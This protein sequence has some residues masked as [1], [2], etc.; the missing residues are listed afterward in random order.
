[1]TKPWRAF[2]VVGTAIF[3]TILDLFIVNTALPAVAAEFPQT[4]VAHLSWVLTIYAIVF[5][6]VLVPAGKFG[7]LYGRRRFFIGGM[8]VFVLGSVIASLAPN[9]ALLLAGR[10]V[11]AVGAASITPNSLAALLP[12][13]PPQRRPAVIAAWGALAGLGGLT[14]PALGGIL[15]Q[16]DWR[17]IFLIN[18]PVGLAALA[19]TPRFIPEVR[20][21]AASARPDLI[22]AALLAVALAALTL[23]LSQGPQWDW[24][25]RGLASL[26]LAAV[27]VVVVG[28]RSRRHPAPIIEPSLLSGPVRRLTMAA[29][30]VFWAAFAILLVA[31]A[32][33]MTHVWGFS[34]L[35]T[36]L[37]LTPGPAIAVVGAVLSSRLAVRVGYGMLGVAGGVMVAVAGAW[38]AAGL[39][40]EPAYATVYLPVQLVGGF[41]FG[42]LP[43]TL[44]AVT[45]VGLPPSRLSTGIAVYSIFR[46]IG[47]VLG[48]A[49][50]VA[51]LGDRATTDAA[52]FRGGW[53]LVA[54]L[55][56]ATA[57]CMAGIRVFAESPL[58]APG[59]PLQLAKSAGG[60]A[61]PPG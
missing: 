15:A 38:M 9:P 8:V 34:V 48:V 2:A 10:A 35:E 44:I 53:M 14:G 24:D 60:G 16:A 20:D 46:Q 6:A 26:T 28:W 4:P 32:L 23:G 3:L 49:A 12:V 36:G 18:I 30:V 56:I 50:W 22:G 25:V 39:G 54:T 51:L 57:V 58:P 11:Q 29:T 17:L 41:G 37:A 61:E 7:D 47:V 59:D 1:M 21:E 19:L 45:V 40:A 27:L 55:G 42:L 31:S 43:P 13:F 52:A 33:F 5:A